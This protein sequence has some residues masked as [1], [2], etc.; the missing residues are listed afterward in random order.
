[1]GRAKEQSKNGQIFKIEP[2]IIAKKNEAKTSKM[3]EKAWMGLFVNQSKMSQSFSFFA[4]IF[5]LDFKNLAVFRLFFCSSHLEI[6]HK[7][8]L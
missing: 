7:I 3:L 4:G 6:F 1:M 5:W 8:F 2:K